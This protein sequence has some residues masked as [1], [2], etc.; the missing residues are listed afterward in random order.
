MICC[1]FCIK[2]N[3]C[4]HK[5]SKSRERFRTIFPGH[6]LFLH[7]L[8]WRGESEEGKSLES[9]HWSCLHWLLIW[10][11]WDWYST[12]WGKEPSKHTV[13]LYQCSSRHFA[14]PP[15]P[16]ESLDPVSTRQ[17]S[18]MVYGGVWSVF[19]SNREASFLEKLLSTDSEG[20]CLTGAGQQ[21]SSTFK[22]IAAVDGVSD[23]SFAIS[24]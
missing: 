3:L 5:Y 24:E 7:A 22:E 23:F 12:E 4:L 19:C 16:A 1:N 13:L 20:C 14:L 15:Y 2:T 9:F 10:E 11:K 21:S 17:D 8:K 6:E 18:A